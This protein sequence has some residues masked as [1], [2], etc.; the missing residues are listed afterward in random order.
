MD[1]IN[2]WV[3]PEEVKRIAESLMADVEQEGDW[4]ADHTQAVTVSA[5]KQGGAKDVI[6]LSAE[7]SLAEASKLA[8]TSGMLSREKKPAVKVEASPEVQTPV[9][10]THKQQVEA[11]G[12]LEKLEQWIRE[13][14]KA[15]GVCVVDRDGDVLL[16]RMDN[17]AWQNLVIASA[18]M[19][20]K[21]EEGSIRL[22]VSGGCHLQLI[23]AAT[24]R[25]GILVG[26]LLGTP[27]A[28]KDAFELARKSE[29]IAND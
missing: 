5:Q 16:S 27:V 24:S 19:A 3:D 17:G 28:Q 6:R 2:S 9:E 26:V 7:K 1:S 4:E 25:G 13:E 14:T 12:A 10:D 15:T 18:A 29:Q 22:R 21:P 11:H 20:E 8:S 23:P